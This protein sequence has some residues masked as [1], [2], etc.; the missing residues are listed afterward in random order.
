MRLIF[1]LIAITI[2]FLGLS[3]CGDQMQV[4]VHE[5]ATQPTAAPTAETPDAPYIVNVTEQKTPL[6]RGDVSTEN[7]NVQVDSK[8][9][10]VR[11]KGKV[12]LRDSKTKKI[13]ETEVEL[14][15]KYNKDGFAN[16]VPAVKDKANADLKVRSK[17]TCLDSNS[18]CTQVVADIFVQDVETK[19][20]HFTQVESK[21]NTTL[22]QPVPV[23]N[24]LPANPTTPQPTVPEKV[25]EKN[26][27]PTTPVKPP[28]KPPTAPTVVTEDHPPVVDIVENEPDDDVPDLYVGH[29]YT[30]F[31]QMFE[32]SYD[33]EKDDTSKLDPSRPM[34]QAYSLPPMRLANGSDLLAR[35]ESLNKSN[36]RQTQ[37][38]VELVNINNKR[39]YGTYELVEL[40]LSIGYAAKEMNIS[41][42][43]QVNTLSQ[44][45][46]GPLSG[47]KSH[48]NGLDAD[49]GF[50]VKDFR[51]EMSFPKVVVGNAMTSNFLAKETLLLFKSLIKNSK[52][53]VVDRIFVH[54]TI[55]AGLCKKA[56]EMGL[57]DAKYT[58]GEGVEILRR[59]RPL[60]G[61]D[62]H[63]HLRIK[64]S[65]YQR[66]CR[67]S[68]EMP[69]GAGC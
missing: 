36:N 27:T 48:Q 11:I 14:V 44:K 64:C 9:K 12:K 69:P 22:L 25:P 66:T 28:E 5:Y 15:G 6:Y 17:I 49:I 57:V 58:S 68:Q 51:K 47:H 61:H 32:A 41:Q 24:P 65:K 30:S 45:S 35:V 53:A 10:T 50:F 42:K 34:N 59:L 37:P 46:G 20:Y 54:P 3:S 67:Q 33:P 31:E 55:K 13:K 8:T 29:V 1:T 62:N 19:T 7:M 52:S 56:V 39:Y 21:P 18:E 16:L 60:E 23:L 2:A 4:Q 26:P 43:L 40:I 38:W 63:F